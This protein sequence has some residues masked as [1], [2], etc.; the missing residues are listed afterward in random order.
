MR[1]CDMAVAR[2]ARYPRGVKAPDPLIVSW[3]GQ[4]LRVRHDDPRLTPYSPQGATVRSAVELASDAEGLRL[5]LMTTVGEC[6]RVRVSD[7]GNVVSLWRR[8]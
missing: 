1:S 2:P 5:V 7:D 6:Y 3:R 4:Q 8:E